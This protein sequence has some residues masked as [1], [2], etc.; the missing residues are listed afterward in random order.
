M[1]PRIVRHRIDELD[2]PPVPPGLDPLLW[3]IYRARGVHS[4]AELDRGLDRLLP[5][6]GLNG[7]DAAVRLLSDAMARGQRILV[8][9]DFDADGA[10]SC[11][12]AVR[13]LKAMGHRDVD[14][15]VPNRFEFGYGLT[16]EIVEVARDFRPDLLITVDNGVSSVAGVAAARALG[17]KVLVT[18]HH[19]AGDELPA[20]DALV[21]PNAP[22]CGFPSKALAGV[23]VIFYVMVALR[24]HLR[25]IG[26]FEGARK[27]P[28]NMAD[29]LD[30]V[31]LGTV[32]DVVPLDRNNR[33]LVHQ[34]LARIR[35][36]RCRPGVA[37]LLRVAGRDPASSRAV[38]MAFFAGPR[39]NAAGRLDDMSIGIRCLLSD[40]EIEARQLADRLDQLNR[41]RRKIE[42][43][44][45]REAE[46]MLSDR[47][48]FD[49]AA[50]PWGVCLHRP[51]WHQGVIGILASRVKEKL[52]RPVIIFAD[53]GEDQL[54]GSARSIPG[55]HIRDT[56][57]EIA[58]RQPNILSRF[59]G[60]AMAAG[61]SL[62][63]ADLGTFAE[64]FDAVVRHRLNPADLKAEIRSDGELPVERLDLQTA[65]S[66]AEGGP[67]GQGFEEPVFDGVFEVVDNRIVG[68]KHWKVQLRP[69]GTERVLDGIAFNGVEAMPELPPVIHA[70]YRLERNEWRGRSRLQLQL[71]ALSEAL[72]GGPVGRE[73]E[74]DSGRKGSKKINI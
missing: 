28:P 12:V 30:L 60:H 64:T 7:M 27:G 38:D 4:A 10:T 72:E 23:G 16:P 55:L 48:L 67:W 47:D 52:H 45:K 69:R 40:S 37:A 74:I 51:G 29:Y 5:P 53:D 11:A 66:I 50:Q 61:L 20:A 49:E 54:K 59:G 43:E 70:A 33:I 44:M 31:A 8:V 22:G 73:T 56:L 65:E 25:E 24:G 71:L 68:D 62:R 42:N 15:L 14:F 57:D 63:R 21:N 13:A 39:L 19:L 34:G 3:G 58:V 1:K 18:D 17:W 9:G 2:A 26:W 46:Q 36:G 35:A 32:A 6:S 41:A